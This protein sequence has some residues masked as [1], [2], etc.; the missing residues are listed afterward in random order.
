[1]VPCAALPDGGRIEPGPRSRRLAGHGGAAPN[2]VRE[3]REI[4]PGRPAAARPADRPPPRASRADTGPPQESYTP[5]A[6][7]PRRRSRIPAEDRGPVRRVGFARPVWREPGQRPGLPGVD[8]SSLHDHDAGRGDRI[9]SAGVDRG[10]AQD[11]KPKPLEAG[12]QPPCRCV[13]LLEQLQ[14]VAV[15]LGYPPPRDAEER[16]NI[17]EIQVLEIVQL[18]D[19]SLAIGERLDQAL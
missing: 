19:L 12:V 4:A 16:R 1:M 13:S 2:D 8:R 7:D 9:R 15:H 11:L 6:V 18:D 10:A 14:G 3:S 5:P 17:L